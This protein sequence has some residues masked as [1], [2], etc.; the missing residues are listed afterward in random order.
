M[1]AR[2]TFLKPAFSLI[3]VGIA[4]TIVIML[5]IVTYS[6]FIMSQQTQRK[7]DSRAEI[8][9]NQ[10]A[11]FDRLTR[12]LR[13]ANTILTA[14]PASELKFE[15]GHGNLAGNPTVYVRYYLQGTDLYR[16]V[17]YYYFAPDTI[18][19]VFYSD[20]DG[21]GNP[22]SLSVTEDRLVGE[23][24]SSLSF[25]GSGTITVSTTFTNN[26]QILTLTS[27]VSPRNA[28]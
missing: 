9:Q 17:S 19:H 26:S 11:T 13:Q 5:M 20:T 18:T 14:L 22:P 3:E 10:R 6:V 27:D 2:A 15:D 4:V 23:Y 24:V 21:G 25:S 7:V 1:N 28:N 12:E 16:E 8:V